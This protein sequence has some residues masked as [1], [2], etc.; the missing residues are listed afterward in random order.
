M[1]EFDRLIAYLSDIAAYPE[2]I[3]EVA[4][5]QTQMSVVFLVGEY[6]YKI[7][8]P[9]NLGYVDY[10]RLEHRKN[11]CER[12][13]T[14]NR[15]LCPEIYLGV[16]PIT[17]DGSKFILGGMGS[18]I[19]Y[20]VKMRRLPEEQLL[21]NLLKQDKVT[22]EMMAQVASRLA[23]FHRSAT[24]NAEIAEFGSLEAITRNTEENF[25]QTEKYIGQTI[26]PK[27]FAAIRD[28]TR[29]FIRENRDLF[30][31]R[32]KDGWIRDC[33]GDLHA[34]HICFHHGLS[35]F[36]CIEFSDR[37]RYS[38]TAAEAAFLAMDLEHSGRA[39]LAR[40]FVSA[41]AA[42]S[43]DVDLHKLLVFYKCYRACVRG[44][45]NNFKL[46]DPYIRASDRQ[47]SFSLAQGYFDLAAAYTRPKPL[48]IIM[49][50]FVGSGKT[51]MAKV[52]AGKLGAVYLSSD[53]T[54]KKLAGIPLTEHRYHEPGGGIYS[55]EFTR[56]T[57]NMLYQEAA[58]ALAG[59]YPVILDAAFLKRS[60]RDAARL[61]AARSGADCCVLECRAGPEIVRSRLNMRLG[62]PVVSDGTWDI[63]LKQQEWFEPP[64]IS[65]S[66]C[67]SVD[68]SGP[69]AQNVRRI[70]ERFA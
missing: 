5:I 68:T 1:S 49:M 50:G 42:E 29:D 70:L 53:I 30:I 31:K 9:V 51:T 62:Q 48:L 6:T 20:A 21:D 46:D 22:P 34:Q 16:V 23:Q 54:R 28:Y 33:H 58:E 3:G 66:G 18:P 57:Y 60:E 61:I 2:G 14:L 4:V 39:D 55:A 25:E 38:D 8:K 52:L 56:R 44:K 7:K 63:Y 27:S 10:T 47:E 12:E 59:G 67:V 26:S 65:E 64:D 11:F 45:V 36:D 37:F 24:T 13:V 40:L 69:L 17:K 41:Y 32:A 35:I 15:R 43:G 19:E